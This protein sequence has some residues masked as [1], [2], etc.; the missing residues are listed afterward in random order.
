[1][2]PTRYGK[3]QGSVSDEPR[4]DDRSYQDVDGHGA[5]GHT[6][7]LRYWRADSLH[8]STETLAATLA[9]AF[10]EAYDLALRKQES[11]GPFNILRSPG[12]PLNGL[13]VRLS[14]KQARWNHM[15]DTGNADRVNESLRETFM[16]ALNY[17]AFAVLIL[18]GTFPE[19]E[20]TK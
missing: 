14:D 6:G 13:R 5:G 20:T 10:D 1:V 9:A 19:Q 8:P 18:D 12:G 16:D 3:W 2:D 17:C 11:Y 15:L 4:S 7:R